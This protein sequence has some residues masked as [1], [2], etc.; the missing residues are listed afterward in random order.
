MIQSPDSDGI[1]TDY[2]G[3][4][5]EIDNLGHGIVKIIASDLMAL[6]MTKA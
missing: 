5:K 6:M 4:F 3:F 2:T 1:L